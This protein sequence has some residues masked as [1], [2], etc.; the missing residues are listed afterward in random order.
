VG[1]FGENVRA[2]IASPGGLEISNWFAI[3]TLALS[4]IHKK[5]AEVTLCHSRVTI[6]SWP[7]F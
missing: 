6:R 5:W 3:V 2:E 7:V 4:F 1:F